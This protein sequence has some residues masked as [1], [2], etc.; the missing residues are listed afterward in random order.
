MNA[1][2]NRTSSAELSLQPEAISLQPQA[3]TCPK[4]QHKRTAADN[5][6]DWQCPNCGIA[7]NKATAQA[8]AVVHKVNRTSS[9]RGRQEIDRDQWETFTPGVIS[10]SLQGRI[11]RLRYLAFSWPNMALSGVGMA[12]AVLGILHKQS[13]NIPLLILVGVL[14]FWLSLRLM[15]LRLHDVNRS[16]KWLLALV[17]LPAVSAALHGG[18][19]MVAICSG[20]FWVVALLLIV[21]PGSEGDN[22]YGPPPG[23][24]TI[25]VK[26]GAALLIAFM[27]LGVV[28]N[29]KYM[30]YV[31]SGKLHA[32]LSG[33]PGTSQE[34]PGSG[35]IQNG[36]GAEMQNLHLT[37]FGFVGT[38]EGQKISLR[39]DN[40]GNGDL[41]RFDGNS[42]VRAVGPLRILDGNRISIGFG[43]DPL[44]L[45]VTVPPHVEGGA[46]RMTLDGIELVRNR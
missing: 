6:P 39:V 28:A 30:Q 3:I 27:A 7:Y 36:A 10:L 4:C 29:L 24:N 16:A 1:N 18:P 17:L 43:L 33:A 22:D 20:L 38:W 34:Q 32:A 46:T 31:R 25:L 8:D 23:A 13:P 21:L 45:N 14:W 11:G 2:I 5:G 35:N 40:F 12:A 9:A 37:K 41:S 19:Q 26:V 44:V 42:T 15:A